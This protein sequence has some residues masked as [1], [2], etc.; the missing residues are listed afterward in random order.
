[1][2]K[3]FLCA[4]FTLFTFFIYAQSETAL[5]IKS[6]VQ[7]LENG[8]DYTIAVAG[9]MPDSLYHY[10]PVPAEMSFGEQLI[11]ISQN[12]YGLSSGYIINGPNP[13]H[14]TKEQLSKLGKD[15]IIRLVNNAYDY[16]ISSINKIDTNTLS[17]Q[18]KFS[19]E[20]L[21]KYQFLNLI[22]DHQTHH[23]GQLIVYLRLNGIAPP[24]YI[25]W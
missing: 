21:N 11:H 5:L 18:F 6:H 4:T 9:L 23:R 22:E 13:F 1:M 7:K 14:S 17:K 20:K 24:K 3:L 2:K 10:K 19:G 8:K 15:S 16:A 12:L 25:G